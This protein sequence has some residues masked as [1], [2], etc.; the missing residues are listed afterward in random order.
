[1][2]KGEFFV[3]FMICAMLTAMSFMI[4]DFNMTS[5][6]ERIQ[7]QRECITQVNKKTDNPNELEDLIQACLRTRGSR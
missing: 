4:Y 2:T 7:M 3:G 6:S 5:S 1:M